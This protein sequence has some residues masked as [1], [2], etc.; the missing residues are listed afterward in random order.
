MKIKGIIAGAV[1]VTAIAGAGLIMTACL[2][3]GAS[4]STDTAGYRS[5]SESVE[6]TGDVH[7]VESTTYYSSV[8]APVND[9]DLSLGD[10]VAAGQ[11]VLGYDLEDLINLFIFGDRLLDR[12]LCRLRDQAVL[13]SK[14]A[15]NT[16]NGQVQASNSNQAKYNK[17]A[18][19]IEVYRN[20]YWLFRQASDYIDQGQYQEN[21]DVNCIADGINKNIAQ[22]T[23]DL[24]NATLELQNEQYSILGITYFDKELRAHVE[25]YDYIKAI[26]SLV[27]YISDRSQGFPTYMPVI[28][29]GGADA[30]TVNDLIV[31]IIKKKN[32]FNITNKNIFF[33]TYLLLINTNIYFFLKEVKYH[34]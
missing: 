4:Y 12:R 10:E 22:K 1:S 21:W 29:T 32:N 16:M 18:S 19:D 20:T 15:E 31:F 33:F 17:A 30:G 9:Y 26:S 34:Y 7:G 13:T 5:I 2:G 27:R 23:A 14:S 25:K 3:K 11:H 8:T 6:A 28:G 24:N